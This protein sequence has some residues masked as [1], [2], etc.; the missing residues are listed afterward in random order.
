VSKNN[1]A[2]HL[3]CGIDMYV[4]SDR[5]NKTHKFERERERER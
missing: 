4:Q 3:S 2:S 5:N 1:A